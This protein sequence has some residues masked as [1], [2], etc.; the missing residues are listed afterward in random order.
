MNESTPSAAQDSTSRAR[1]KA[2][3]VQPFCLRCR[4]LGPVNGDR[5]CW[6]CD[7]EISGEVELSDPE[8]A[9]GSSAARRRFNGAMA[10]F[11]G[12]AL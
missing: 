5:L 7:E 9:R 3:S 11:Y 2:A 1:A 12:L 6:L 10:E 8:D 4:D